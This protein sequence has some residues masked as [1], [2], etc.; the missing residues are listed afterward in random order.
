MVLGFL[1]ETVLALFKDRP[2]SLGFWS[3][4]A[5]GETAAWRLKWISIP[6]TL[7]VMCGGRLIYRS[8]LE[9]PDRFVGMKHAK[10][11]LLASIAVSLL[12][13]TLI[14][15]TIPARLRQR[16]M[17]AE[18]EVN[19]RLQTIA[20]AQL[21][22]Q[23]L[24][25]T[26][27]TNIRDLYDLPDQDGSIAAALT[28]VE[29]AEYQPHAEI[30]VAPVEKGRPLKGAEIRKASVTTPAE[31]QPA[32]GLAFTDYDLRLA[33]PD[34][35]LGTDDDLVLRNGVIFPV[36][37]LKNPPILPKTPKRAAKR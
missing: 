3:W 35:I 23:A 10:R 34:K 25:G 1:T 19:A 31:D 20:R 27:A 28:F 37:D 2:L 7:A 13:A 33:G 16:Q 15:V 6:I 30:A 32:A 5:A 12:I 22:Y 8:M 11:G 36:S 4:V 26:F 29:Q 24:H 21:E 18:A 14:G 9:A 17:A